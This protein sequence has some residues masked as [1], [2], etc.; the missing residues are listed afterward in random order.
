[1][2]LTGGEHNTSSAL[3]SI[4]RFWLRSAA[5]CAPARGID[6]VGAALKQLRAAPQHPGQASRGEHAVAQRA[7]N[8]LQVLRRERQQRRRARA[9]RRA[10]LLRRQAQA[11]QQVRLQSKR[12]P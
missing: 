1:M 9:K 7:G 6:V 10:G 5:R 8:G 12:R 2:R 3:E 11:E 4:C